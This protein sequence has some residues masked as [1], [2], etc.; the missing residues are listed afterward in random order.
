MLNE[1]FALG[2]SDDHQPFVNDSKMWFGF[3]ALLML[4]GSGT[5]DEKLDGWDEMLKKT[6]AMADE[7]KKEHE[8]E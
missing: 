3:L 6:R 8:H 2:L 4:S 1:G 5:L 7:I